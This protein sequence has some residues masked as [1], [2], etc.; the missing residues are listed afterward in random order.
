MEINDYEITQNLE[1]VAKFVIFLVIG[2][3]LKGLQTCKCVNLS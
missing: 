1:S 2:K 3:M